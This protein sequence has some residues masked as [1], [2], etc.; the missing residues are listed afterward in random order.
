MA[1]PLPASF[2]PG[3]AIP[4]RKIATSKTLATLVPCGECR[5]SVDP[6]H[7]EIHRI[8]SERIFSWARQHHNRTTLKF[9]FL[10]SITDAEPPGVIIAV[11]DEDDY[12][13][14]LGHPYAE[15]P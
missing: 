10:E 4:T 14:T 9:E 1:T 15:R 3:I 7:V 5:A 11:W 2:R 8:M 12:E 6:Q 13:R